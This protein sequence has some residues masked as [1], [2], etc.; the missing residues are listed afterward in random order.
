MALRAVSPE[1]KQKRLKML[2]FGPPAVGKT[3]AAIQWP[4]NYII[5][6]EK[7]TDA[8]S[9][10][11]NRANS[12]VFQTN[13]FDEVVKEV[14]ELLTTKHDYRTL[15][16]DPI[17]NVYNAVQEKWSK[18]FEKYA[19]NEKQEETQDYGMR[20]W[21]RVKSDFKALQRLI[22]ALDMNVLV[23]S[24]QKDMY[25]P[26]MQKIG[27]SF[28]SMKGEDYLYDYV[29]RLDIRNGKR[30]AVTIKERAEIGKNKFPLEFEWSYENFKKYYGANILEKESA[31]LVLASVDQINKVKKLIEVVKVSDEEITNWFTKTNVDSWE[32][33]PF[34][35][36][37][38]II[39]HLYKKLT[40]VT[41]KIA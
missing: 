5:D 14:K 19:K 11:I 2:M 33:F 35:K 24:H 12:V 3:T 6:T 31:P 17:T 18:V 34:E 20:Y 4:Q 23:T 38:K 13:I 25:G 37:E 27:V 32:E 29:F 10:S 30:I 15:T 8:Y 22:L 39:D 26:G 28:D 1:I 40:Q 41:E 9:E 36:L 16:I 21:A 7:G